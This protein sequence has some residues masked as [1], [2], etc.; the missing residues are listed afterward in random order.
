MAQ[1]AEA[2]SACGFTSGVTYYTDRYPGQEQHARI[3]LSA[4]F[5]GRMTIQVIVDTGAPWCVLDPEIA[6][7]LGITTHP[8]YEPTNGLTIRGHVFEGRLYRM[9]ICL[10]NE[11]EDSDN[12]EIEATV[13]VPTLPVGQEWPFPNFI[14]LDGFLSRIRFAIDPQESAFYYNPT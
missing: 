3:V 12:P 14:G 2:F 6:D 9:G 1:F 4:T 13:F 10:Q 8:N 11:G 5:E 7:D